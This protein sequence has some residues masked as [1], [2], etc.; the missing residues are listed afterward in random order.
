MIDS[1]LEAVLKSG[2]LEKCRD[3]FLGMPEKERRK[4]APELGKLF[5]KVDKSPSYDEATRIYSLQNVDLDML[6]LAVFSTGTLTEIKKLGFRG[7]PGREM[8]YEIIVDRRPEWIEEWVAGLFES[9]RFSWYWGIIRKLYLDGLIQKPDHPNYTLGMINYLQPPG[10]AFRKDEPSVEEAISADPTLLEDEIWRLF[11]H[12]GEGVDS[13]A[14]ADGSRGT[15]DWQTA[16]LYFEKRGELSRERLLT[17]SLE[18]LERD[19]N[20]YRAK[21]FTVFHDGLKPS[22]EE[23]KSLAPH[24]LQILGV[25]AAPVVSWAYAKVEQLAKAGAYS[26]DD[27]VAGL[28]PVLQARQ[29]GIVKKALKLLATLAGKR[30]GEAA[31][32]VVAALPALGHEAVEVQTDVLGMIEKFGDVNDAKFVRDVSEYASVVAP[33]ERKRLDAWLA[34]AGAAPEVA[35]AAAEEVAEIDDAAVDAMDERLRHLYAIDDL[36]ANR[37]Q[38]KLEIPAA[39]FD[40][41]EIP[42]LTTHQPIQPIEDLD[43]LIEVCTRLIEDAKSIDDVERAL[44]GLSRLCGEK[45]DDFDLRT[46]P[47]LKRCISLMKQERSPFVGAGPGEDLIGLIIAWCKG[48]VLEAKPGKSKFGHKV[49]N[50]TIDGEAIQ[51]FSSNLEPPIG[52]LS[53]RVKTIAGRVAA[54]KAAPLWSAPTHAGAWIEPQVLVDRVLASGGKPLDD[55]DAVLALL[56][57]APEGREAALANLKTAATEAAKAV[58]YALGA[59]R[60]TIGKSAPIWTAAARSRAPWSDDAQ[61]EKAFPKSGPDAATAAAYHNVIWCDEYKDYNRTYLVARFSMESTP[62]APKTIDPLCITTRFHWGYQAP[63]KE[64]WERRSCGGHSEYGIAWT[65]SIWPQARESF[66]ASGV[67]VM[68]NNID[69]DSAAWGHK[70]F[71]EPLLD[72]TTPLREM[73][74]MLLVIGLGAK[75]PGEHGLATDAAIAAIEEGRLGSDNLGAM[76]ARLLRTGL[77]KPPRWAKTLADVARISTL[78]AAVVHHAIQISLAGDAETLPRDYAKLLE[79]LLQLSIE[80]ELPVTHAGCLETLQNL[81]GSGKGP[82]TAKALLKRPPATEETV[83]RILDLALQQRIRA[84]EAVA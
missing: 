16:L 28:K 49:M 43:E 77:I 66:F 84:A 10:G 8:M 54:E 53:E 68:G 46:A 15:G 33:S 44:D 80:L 1:K 56:R 47:L 32:I 58:R 36:L 38:G 52:F 45:P 81:P 82:K 37:Q 14:N 65:A 13:L 71:L 42:R 21:W 3:Y 18:A 62:R 50:Y 79:L 12:E 20:H 69:W 60:V 78:H 70:A 48:V 57:L 24:Y 23:L 29:K 4:L 19:F 75:E 30:K 9:P 39:R 11:E 59:T 22:D 34:A 17:S 2:D 41:T 61:L 26:A 63:I 7:E 64:H 83:Q 73:G 40:G 72:S 5:R 25:S 55:F 6:G 27:L 74:L 51:Q 67:C 35:D 31:K 76:L